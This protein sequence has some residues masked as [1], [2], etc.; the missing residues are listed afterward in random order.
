MDRLRKIVDVSTIPG[1]VMIR[2]DLKMLR[3]VLW[4][5]V[6]SFI[7]ALSVHLL[8]HLVIIIGFEACP[9]DHHLYP[10]PQASYVVAGPISDS[11]IWQ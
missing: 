8:I 2:I 6:E 1:Q 3:S 4:H 5:F 9:F 10:K 11:V 7:I